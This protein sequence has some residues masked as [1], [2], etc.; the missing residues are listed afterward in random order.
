MK[1][2]I[3]SILSLAML[4]GSVDAAE[5]ALT[6]PTTAQES[7][8]IA[9]VRSGFARGLRRAIVKASR[10]GDITRRERVRL[11]I[12]ILSPAFV[13]AAEDLAVIQMAFS[14][15]DIPVTSDG[16]IDRAAIDWGG[17]AD[18]L[19]RLLPLLLE[20]LEFGSRT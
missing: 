5:P 7:V 19:E 3:V 18:F 11:S 1:T 9:R 13:E 17:L 4:L 20:L 14:G 12:A 6:G 15:D 16:S 2:L 8:A 10:N